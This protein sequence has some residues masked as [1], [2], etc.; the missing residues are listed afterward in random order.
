MAPEPLPN[1][2]KFRLAAKYR[3]PLFLLL[4][5]IVIQAVF[6]SHV[7]GQENDP[8]PVRDLEAHKSNAPHWPPAEGQERIVKEELDEPIQQFTLDFLES[9]YLNSLGPALDTLAASG[10]M[11]DKPILRNRQMRIKIAA[12]V[13]AD[14]SNLPCVQQITLGWNGWSDLV[15]RPDNPP[16]SVEKTAAQPD[17]L[18]SMA[19]PPRQ[20]IHPQ[21]P[22]RTEVMID[23]AAEDTGHI[24]GSVTSEASGLP[25]RYI[26]AYAYYYGVDGWWSVGYDQTDID[27]FYDISGLPAGL[28][29]IGFEDWRYPDAI[30]LEEYYDDASDLE[31][32]TDITLAAGATFSSADASLAVGSHITGTVTAENGG[33]LPHNLVIEAYQFNGSFWQYAGTDYALNHGSYDIGGLPA[34]N[35]RI[36]FFDMETNYIDEYYDNAPDIESGMDI[37]VAAHSTITDIDASLTTAAHITGTVTAEDSG[38]DLQ[39]VFVTAYRFNGS[40]WESRMLTATG[41]DGTYDIGG[42]PAGT[43]RLGF[44]DTYNDLYFPEYYDNVPDIENATDISVT[45]AGTISDIDASLVPG[46]GNLQQI[47]LNV[48]WNMISSYINPDT[49]SMEIVLASLANEMILIKNDAGQVYWPAIPVDDIGEWD[50]HDGYHIYMQ[51]E[52]ELYI[53]GQPVSPTETPIALGSGWSTV[54][55]LRGMFMP[56]YR[57]LDTVDDVL[58][59]AKNG[60]GQ[61]YWPAYNVDQ[62]GTM[63]P[64][65]GYQLY[66]KEPGGALIYPGYE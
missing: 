47:H 41:H 18:G 5:F 65:Q 49:P 25:L 52:A 38:E 4:V 48:G 66:V 32:A 15:E 27:G 51:S 63:E 34:D 44:S 22:E 7:S 59:L 24:T 37:P 1:H 13:H 60:A 35:Y 61:V 3:S 45:V 57:A 29:R 50:V 58:V 28:Y 2:A 12:G 8:A 64:G 55:F 9:C 20:P 19:M 23:T 46:G 43:Y 11:V 14:L 39:Y 53:S 42:L 40:E 30:Y 56:A 62:I 31:N 16:G 21:I 17:M 6:V 10:K 26:V 36:Y 33:A 54:S